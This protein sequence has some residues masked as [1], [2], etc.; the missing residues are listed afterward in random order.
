MNNTRA[1]LEGTPGSDKSSYNKPS[2]PKN[3]VQKRTLEVITDAVHELKNLNKKMSTPTTAIP[4]DEC[5]AMGKHIAIQLRKLPPYDR[6]LANFDL[7]KILMDYRLRNM[8]EASSS[9]SYNRLNRVESTIMSNLYSPP[10]TTSE[11]STTAEIIV[12]SGMDS[13]VF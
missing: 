8:R 4:E 5:D 11:E 1:Q 13:D 10:T 6:V 9:S 3:Q 2:R 7:Q 12:C